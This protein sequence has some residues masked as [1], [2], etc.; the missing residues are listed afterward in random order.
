MDDNYQ[1]AYKE[2]YEILKCMPK[3]EVEKI[4]EEIKDTIENF[5][6]KNYDFKVQA[7]Q[8]FDKQPILQETKA[9][10]AV[11]YRDYWATEIERKRIIQ[12]QE[13]DL[14]K[15]EER[16]KEIYSYENLFKNRKPI[17][18]NNEIKQVVV[19]KQS[20]YKKFVDFVKQFLGRN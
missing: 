6:D 15:A 7:E 8:D 5:M 13:Y 12:K 2:V 9:I 20:W 18:E 3:E 17:Q 14:K 10:L 16:K 19:Y 11:L 4:P 1:K